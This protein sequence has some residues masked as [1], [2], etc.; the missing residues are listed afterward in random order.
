MLVDLLGLSVLAEKTSKHSH[1]THPQDLERHTGVHGTLAVTIAGVT[2]LSL[3]I[4][5]PLVTG[6]GVHD[7]M[8]LGDK[9]V[10]DEL[11]HVLTAVGVGDLRL[12]VGVQPDLLGAASEDGGS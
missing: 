8:L 10:L 4:H 11:T 6:L 2:S 9:T 5:V 1:A 3:G 12:L 7:N